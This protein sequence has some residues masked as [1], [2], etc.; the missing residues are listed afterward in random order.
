[1]CVELNINRVKIAFIVS[2]SAI[3]PGALRLLAQR[4]AIRNLAASINTCAIRA[5]RLRTP[6]AGIKTYRAISVITAEMLLRY[7]AIA[8]RDRYSRIGSD[9]Y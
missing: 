4:P 9:V 5:W 7:V 8:S 1:M 3:I 2:H 6:G